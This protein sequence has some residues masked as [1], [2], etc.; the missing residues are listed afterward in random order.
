MSDFHKLT[1]YIVLSTVHTYCANVKENCGTDFQN[2]DF[3]FFWQIFEILHLDSLCSSSTHWFCFR[4]ICWLFDVVQMGRD[5]CDTVDEVCEL[6]KALGNVTI[7]KKGPHDVIA[8]ADKCEFWV[9]LCTV[10]Q[11]ISK[12][13]KNR[14]NVVLIWVMDGLMK[15]SCCQLTGLV[16]W[17]GFW[18]CLV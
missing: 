2:F 10:L 6:S 4:K 8:H 5:S 13:K 3:K 11:L 1:I 17:F 12:W 16:D 7:V 9:Q 18:S 14:A 15:E